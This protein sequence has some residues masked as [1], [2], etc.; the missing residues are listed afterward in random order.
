MKDNEQNYSLQK[1]TQEKNI[2]LN[3]TLE[4]LTKCNLNCIHCYIPNHSENGLDENILDNLFKNLREMGALYLNITGGEIFLHKN[5]MQIIK[6]ARLLGFSTNLLSNATLLNEDQIKELSYLHISSFGTTVFSINPRVH[7]SITQVNGS[8]NKTIANI[9]LLQKYNIPV[10]IKTPVITS[11][12][13]EIKAVEKFCNDNNFI[14]IPSP[15]ITPKSNRDKSPIKLRIPDDQ[16][17]YVMG[18]IITNSLPST[19]DALKEMR[20]EDSICLQIKNSIFINAVG[21]IFPCINFY[22]KIGDIF[23]SDLK[24]TWYKSPER[25]FLLSLRKK[26]LQECPSCKLKQVCFHCPGQALSE[27][28][29]LYACSPSAKRI[30][31]AEY[32]FNKK[33]G[34]SNEKEVF[35]TQIDP[36]F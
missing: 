30:A 32:R 34:L 20:N 5:I 26:D 36:C 22:F 24:T 18:M 21:E 7:D 10:E 35:G 28:G 14:F 4:L 33:G 23:S 1:L 15:T 27:N 6:K 3:V 8:L 19:E 9:M 25:L 16:M 2:L 31:E 29:S 13:S 11:N 12:L 17:D